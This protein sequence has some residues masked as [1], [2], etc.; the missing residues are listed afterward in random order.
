MSLP[1]IVPKHLALRGPSGVSTLSIDPD[2]TLEALQSLI[3][4][5]TQIPVSEQER[6]RPFPCY[7]VDLQV[8]ILRV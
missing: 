7:G 5:K 6:I 4:T 8:E 3:Y 2:T 1:I